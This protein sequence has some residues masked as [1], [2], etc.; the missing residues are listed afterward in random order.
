M[1]RSKSTPIRKETE[2][3]RLA[4]ELNEALEQQT[5]ASEVLQVISSFA[6]ELDLVFKAILANATRICEAKHG[7]LFLFAD[8]AFQRGCHAWRSRLH[9]TEAAAFNQHPVRAS[10]AWSIKRTA[11][12]IADVLTDRTIR[13]TTHYAQL[14]AEAGG[15]RTLLGVPMI[16]EGELIGAIS[17]FPP[18]GSTVHR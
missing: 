15:V 10:V 2:V 9:L 11:I 3:A 7:T 1:I 8:G 16:K 17:F 5:A 13:A 6:G 4:R 14:L 18:R 12:Q